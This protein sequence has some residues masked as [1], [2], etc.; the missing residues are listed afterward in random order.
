MVAGDIRVNENTAR[1]TIHTVW[2]RLHNYYA[3]FIDNYSR[4]RLGNFPILKLD[5]P[6]SN[7]IIFE[8]ARKIGYCHIATYFLRR[9]AS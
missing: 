6:E 7:I 4:P 9:V 1:A 5:N 3:E 2:V 8:E